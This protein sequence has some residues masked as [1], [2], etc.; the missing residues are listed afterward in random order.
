[1]LAPS[2]LKLQCQVEA[3]WEVPLQKGSI[4]CQ[5]PTHLSSYCSCWM[6]LRDFA[7]P[8]EGEWDSAGGVAPF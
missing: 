5:T 2:R 6:D 8:G 3:H 4:C 7:G 1:M